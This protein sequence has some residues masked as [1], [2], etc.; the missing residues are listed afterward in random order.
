MKGMMEVELLDLMFNAGIGV[1]PQER[2][3][4]N[5]FSVTLKVRYR[6]VCENKDSLDGGISYVDLYDIIKEE[7]SREAQTLEF[8][9]RNIA[10]EVVCRWPSVE[11]GEIEI[12]KLVPP[13]TGIEGRCGVKYF[14]EK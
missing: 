6:T 4:G 14:F 8:V 7:M 9:A 2:K 12:V 11:N 10:K 13:I 1:Y 3:V 5:T